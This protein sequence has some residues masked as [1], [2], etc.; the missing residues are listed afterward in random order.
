MNITT[1]VSHVIHS[2]T[3]VFKVSEYICLTSEV[4]V[5][6]LRI[7][8]LHQIVCVY[9]LASLIPVQMQSKKT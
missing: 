7:G 2:E 5:C 1:T 8:T 6:C 9:I 3:V 4:Q